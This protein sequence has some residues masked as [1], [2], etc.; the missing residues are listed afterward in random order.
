MEKLK[1][2]F[3]LKLVVTGLILSAVT[4]ALVMKIIFAV[5][6]INMP[7]F[8]GTDLEKAR[9]TCARMHIDLKVDD[10]VFSSFYPAGSIMQQDVK[11]GTQIKKGRTFYVIVSKGSKILS[12]P[13]ITNLQKSKALVE[14]K[15][16]GLNEGYE[17]VIT[18]NVFK[19]DTLIAQSPAPGQEVPAGLSINFL[20]SSGKREQNFL[21]PDFSG[22]DA[23]T[24]FNSMRKA[25]LLIEKL[26]VEE[27]ETLASGTI[28][29][30]QPAPGS[31]VNKKTPI[32]IKAGVSATDAKLKKRTIKISFTNPA[33]VPQLVRI[34]VMSLNGSETVFNEVAEP[35]GVVDVNA[36]IRGGAI[37][38]IFNG[39]ELVKETE[40]AD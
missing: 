33:Q 19:E 26:D 39:T 25:G 7:D 11:K 40:Y 14:L 17:T 6:T 15:N 21:M 27:N 23:F 30:Q 12:I 5:S 38:Q 28:I 37:V 29:G 36:A 4:A 9:I 31:M 22:R 34:N 32:T 20:R 35:G 24:S 13:D 3:V 8:T 10:E 18:S 2:S 16:S 1:V